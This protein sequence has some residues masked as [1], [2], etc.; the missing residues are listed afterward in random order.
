MA[1]ASP[2]ME[3]QVFPLVGDPEASVL[4][5]RDVDTGKVDRFQINAKKAADILHDHLQK[6]DVNLFLEPIRKFYNANH[7]RVRMVYLKP[8]DPARILVVTKTPRYDFDLDDA[9]TQLNLD[10]AS[11]DL[12]F[13]HEVI[14]LP[15]VGPDGLRSFGLEPAPQDAC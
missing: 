13:A 15:N 14:Q 6:E 2:R 11:L 7:E 9:V 3:N 10:I 4:V 12:P 8:G 1:H 5:S